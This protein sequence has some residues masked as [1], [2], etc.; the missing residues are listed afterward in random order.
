VWWCR[1]VKQRMVHLFLCL[2]N[3]R[4]FS[5]FWLNR[6]LEVLFLA[7]SRTKMSC[8]RFKYIWFG[9]IYIKYVC[10]AVWVTSF[11]CFRKTDVILRV[12]QSFLF[13]EIQ[14]GFTVKLRRYSRCVCA[15]KK[16]INPVVS[17]WWSVEMG[18]ICL[19]VS[20]FVSLFGFGVREVYKNGDI[21]NHVIFAQ[22]W[23]KLDFF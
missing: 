16:D 4:F 20:F 17:I 14:S 23:G 18:F 2:F 13:R 5:G 21:F 7:N 22:Y 19:V 3:F 8:L 9:F 12:T 1:R 15:V 11:D 6:W 10:V